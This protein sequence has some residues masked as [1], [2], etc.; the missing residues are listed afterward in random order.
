MVWDDWDWLELNLKNSFKWLDEIII[1]WSENSNYGDHSPRPN[2][3]SIEGKWPRYINFEPDLKNTPQ[4]NETLKR[5]IGLDWA[6]K[7]DCTHFLMMDADE[8][9]TEDDIEKGLEEIGD[10]DGLVCKIKTY[11]KSPSLTVGDEGTLVPFIHTLNSKFMFGMNH[12]YPF[13]WTELDRIPFTHG[14]K[15]RID[16][17]RQIIGANQNYITWSEATMHHYSWIRKD[18]KKKIS[19]SSAKMNLV[20]SSIL[21]D[22]VQAKDGYFCEFY[23]KSL[24]ACPNIFGLPEMIDENISI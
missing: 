9:Y 5:N 13:A 11:F 24:E 10:N 21:K 6:R 14:K 1:V 2:M 4:Q 23:R 22:Y 15:I 3:N 17:T 8:F 20:R 7:T 18:I 12:Q 19:N 16:P